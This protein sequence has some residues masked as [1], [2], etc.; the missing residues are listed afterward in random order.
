MHGVQGA[1][2]YMLMHNLTLLTIT[3]HLLIYP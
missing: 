3:I 1:V 2:Y